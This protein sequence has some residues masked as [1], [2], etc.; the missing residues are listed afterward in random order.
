MCT[1]LEAFI[2]ICFIL[3]DSSG[4]DQIDLPWG[5]SS[6]SL[7][8]FS[9]VLESP[10]NQC[11]YHIPRNDR[12]VRRDGNNTSEFNPLHC[13]LGCPTRTLDAA[14]P[15]ASW[16]GGGVLHGAIRACGVTITGD[17]WQGA[18]MVVV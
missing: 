15:A 1:R 4:T 17:A 7:V 2:V 16:R 10:F 5:S 6:P 8:V 3:L 12:G 9:S 13:F 18:H 14:E 11:I